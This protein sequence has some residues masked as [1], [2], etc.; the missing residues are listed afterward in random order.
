[1][2]KGRNTGIFYYRIDTPERILFVFENRAIEKPKLEIK[3]DMKG[4]T[5]EE[6]AGDSDN[7][8]I[9]QMTKPLERVVHS[10]LREKGRGKEKE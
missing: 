1:M 5:L 3:F 7:K 10:M 9:I 4:L 6:P 2:Y 8:W